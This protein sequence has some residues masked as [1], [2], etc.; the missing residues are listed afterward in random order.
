MGVMLM[1][2]DGERADSPGDLQNLYS[3]IKIASESMTHS[4]NI[5]FY[6]SHHAFK[7][8]VGWWGFRWTTMPPWPQIIYPNGFPLNAF[9]LNP[10]RSDNEPEEWALELRNAY[11]SIL[12][13]TILEPD[14]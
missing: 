6:F 13:G 4:P 11:A 10:Y 1:E 12:D 7:D 9:R 2:L 5:M 8:Q 14:D 3:Q